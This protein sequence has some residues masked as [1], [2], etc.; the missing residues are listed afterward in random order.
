MIHQD[1]P[2]APH[3]AHNRF[4]KCSE[5]GMFRAQEAPGRPSRG[6]RGNGDAGRTGG[7]TAAPGLACRERLA[8]RHSP[9]G[10][11]RPSVTLDAVRWTPWFV[12][13]VLGGLVASAPFHAEIARAGSKNSRPD[14]MP[15]EQLRPG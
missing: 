8:F 10:G 1:A 11:G 9:V 5:A 6:S 3:A 15:V 14:V 7:V 4:P 2:R 13:A 12:A